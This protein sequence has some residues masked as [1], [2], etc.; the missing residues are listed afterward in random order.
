MHVELKKAAEAQPEP[1]PVQAENPAVR[2]RLEKAEAAAAAAN[3]RI[4]ALENERAVAEFVDIVKADMPNVSAEHATLGR[5]LK[6]AKDA[7]TEDDF[8]ELTRVLK[9]ASEQLKT[10]DVFKQTGASNTAPVTDDPVVEVNRKAAALQK[11]NP[12]LKTAEAVTQV[13]NSDRK[14]YDR[15]AAASQ[16]KV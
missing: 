15:Y 10:G 4:A 1:D 6:S 13:L 3:V 2:E 12:N 5:I 8:N 7:L 14:L 16:V 9:A 11:D